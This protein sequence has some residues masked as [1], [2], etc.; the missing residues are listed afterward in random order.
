MS[1]VDLVSAGGVVYRHSDSGL[2]VVLCGRQSP[3]IW[4]LPKGTP[5]CG[6]TRKETALREV[7]EETGLKVQAETFLDTIDYW[8]V[9]FSDGNWCHKTVHYYLMTSMGGD[10]SQHDDEFDE[11]KWFPAHYALKAMTY[12]NEAK[13]VGKGISLAT[14]E[15]AKD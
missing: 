6:E 13:I 9:R 10:L 2:D 1:V 4:A 14:Q 7:N 15:V 8:F 3:V 5:D 12:E 11:V